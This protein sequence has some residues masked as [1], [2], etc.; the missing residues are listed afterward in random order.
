MGFPF[1]KPLRRV[2]IEPG[3]GQEPLRAPVPDAAPL[4]PERGPA[5]P[6]PEPAPDA[7]VPA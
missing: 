2:H 5:T 1:E 4:E 6:A 3:P 7:P